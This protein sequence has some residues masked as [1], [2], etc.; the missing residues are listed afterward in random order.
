MDSPYSIGSNSAD[1]IAPL[2]MV[3]LALL[4][5]ALALRMMYRVARDRTGGVVTLVWSVSFFLLLPLS[6]G[7]GYGV[8]IPFWILNVRGSNDPQAGMGAGL[9]ILASVGTL[10][11]IIS[12]ILTGM[13]AAK[14]RKQ[15]AKP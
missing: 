13:A 3:A 15:R 4:A 6:A 10:A 14:G 8:S 11:V 5:A 9:A 2:I 12:A 7:L 1:Y